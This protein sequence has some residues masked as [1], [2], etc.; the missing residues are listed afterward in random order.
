MSQSRCRVK[1]RCVSAERPKAEEVF[2]GGKA[3]EVK[4]LT[5]IMALMTQIGEQGCL[6]KYIQSRQQTVSAMMHVVATS[7]SAA[8]PA[9][10]H[11]ERRV[12][13]C[14]P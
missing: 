13:E 9:A 2:Y 10:A 8:V 4:T 1:W 6:Q 3:R 14:A 7:V 11:T 5:T 12:H